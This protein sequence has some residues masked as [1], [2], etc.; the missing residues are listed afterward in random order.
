MCLLSSVPGSVG[1][2][3]PTALCSTALCHPCPI[4]WGTGLW[5]IFGSSARTRP[6]RGRSPKLTHLPVTLAA[7]LLCTACATPEVTLDQLAPLLEDQ[8]AAWN[9][10]DLDAF[11]DIYWK[12]DDLTFSAGGQTTRG[13]SATR[14]RYK[15]R[16]P[17]PER[18]GKLTFSWLE[19]SPLAGNEAALLL[20]RWRLDREPDPAEG[21]FSLVF[22]RKGP[23]GSWVIIHD[24]SSSTPP[25]PADSP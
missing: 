6:A 23:G 11:M 1:P 19:L 10:G 16:Y 8:A 25:P 2:L 5:T 22:A 21:N 13:W 4:C 3:C 9:R 18:M 20:G 24:H 17:T 14:D 12:S 15:A 7:L